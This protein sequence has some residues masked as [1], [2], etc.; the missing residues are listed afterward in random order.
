MQPLG[1]AFETQ[2]SLSAFRSIHDW[3][4]FIVWLCYTIYGPVGNR[5][6]DSPVQT[7]YFTT[8]LQAQI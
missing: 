7:G 6:R 8:R 5:T 2:L 3:F 1:I 4:Q